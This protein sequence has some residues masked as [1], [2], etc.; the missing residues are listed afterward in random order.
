MKNLMAK[1][2]GYDYKGFFLK[3][4][5]KLGM[6]TAVL[7]VL[8]CLSLTSWSGY[9]GTPEEMQSTAGSV[10]SQ[11]RANKWP[12][13]R[14][15]TEFAQVPGSVA[16]AKVIAPLELSAF[17]HDIPMSPKLYSYRQPAEEPEVLPPSE[18]RV[19]SG[20]LAMQLQTAPPEFKAPSDEEDEEEAAE[21]V[22]A[23]AGGAKT[24]NTKSERRSGGSL[25]VLGMAGG[26]AG[27]MMG[28]S[29]SA[30]DMKARGLRY[31]VVTGYLDRRR[32]LELLKKYLHLETVAEA[33]GLLD[34]VDFK[35]QRQ[36][37][38]PGDKPW[39]DDPATWKE[40]NHTV[41]IEI[42]NEAASFDMDLVPTD[43]INGAITSPLPSR[44]DGEWEFSIVGHPR[45]PAL[46]DESR[47]KELAMNQAALEVLGDEADAEDGRRRGG[48]RRVQRDANDLRSRAAGIDGGESMAKAAS[49]GGGP[50]GMPGGPGGMP[51]GPGGGMPRGMPGG[52]PGGA[53]GGM[54]GAGGG[55]ASAMMGMGA[56]G[57]AGMMG[58][59]G[60]S[61]TALGGGSSGAK[62]LLFRYFDFEVEPGECYR[63]RVQLVINNPSEGAAF[64]SS[65][66]VAE[67]ETRSSA[68]SAPSNPAVAPKDV[69]YSLVKIFKR[70]GRR[71]GAELSVVQYDTDVGTWISH[72]LKMPFGAYVGG[73]Q[74]TPHLDLAKSTFED[75]D[76]VFTSK[77]IMLDSVPAPSLGG[78]ALQD[79]K[80]STKQLPKLLEGGLD[81]AATVDRFGRI[82][83]LDADSRDDI[84]PAK[85]RYE[86][87]N[88]RYE[89]LKE[90]TAAK[91]ASGGGLDASEF[92]QGDKN[93]KDGKGGKKTKA[94]NP[95]KLSSGGG[96]IPGM[97]ASMP[98]MGAGGM[99]G[100]GAA[101]MSG[102][103]GFDA[104]GGTKGGKK[105][106][107]GK[108]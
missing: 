61:G 66:D 23:P 12:E 54:P 27:G 2:K 41:S 5:E 46:D 94:S 32:Q 26:T 78:S 67:G 1:I 64:V 104:G 77:E 93:K 81:Q 53:P 103:G 8:I 101:G 59:S 89:S 18:L 16:V 74:K 37:A 70:S 88:K 97:G 85:K 4:G 100:M 36:R 72:I 87:Q 11:L 83:A 71:E 108:R 40:L 25:E 9:S 17:D 75:E 33:A 51:G 58:M 102:P 7:I 98:G 20:V 90:A 49:Q 29:A 62:G 14:A 30:E 15:T 13:E 82:V 79:L 91:N 31:I 57:G 99:P 48:F 107:G 3:H 50:G 73:K 28:E 43:V 22:R 96:G 95:M 35:V 42:L 80:I 86:D 105:A 34:Y 65:P 24:K 76:V 68:W 92:M 6:G 52:M 69:E 39:S 38:V 106:G 84:R 44:L 19:R 63:Y 21:P 60:R 55:A 45:V 47:E 10:E 56:G